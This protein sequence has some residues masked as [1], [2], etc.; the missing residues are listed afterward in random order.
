MV[1]GINLLP[2]RSSLRLEKE[3]SFRRQILVVLGVVVIILVVWH[4]VLRC[5]INTVI[6]Q[7]THVRKQLSL[8]QRRSQ[9]KSGVKQERQKSEY[10]V[11]R[12]INL[13]KRRIEL[14]RVFEN[15]HRGMTAGLQ[16]TQLVIKKDGAKLFGKANS[17]F[18]IMQLIKS[19]SQTK[20]AMPLVEK[21][22]RQGDEY[23][24]VVL[25]SL[26]CI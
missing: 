2:W 11:G 19:F 26:R 20:C 16:L 10:I 22:N 7:T 1:T 13:E 8:L 5:Q 12:I 9:D 14:I 4:L 17:M 25:L 3:R 23:N 6:K 24:F 18:G 15:L 21:I